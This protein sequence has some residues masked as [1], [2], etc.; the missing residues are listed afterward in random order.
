LR[1]AELLKQHNDVL[2]YQADGDGVDYWPRRGRYGKAVE[3]TR[4]GGICTEKSQ[5]GA[6]YSELTFLFHKSLKGQVYTPLPI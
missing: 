6:L 5:T 1:Y 2:D 4:G 3:G